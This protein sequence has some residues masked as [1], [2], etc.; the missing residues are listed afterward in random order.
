MFGS[1]RIKIEPVDKNNPKVHRVYLLELN[2]SFTCGTDE[3][4]KIIKGQFSGLRSPNGEHAGNMK[5]HWYVPGNFTKALLL[6][7]T[8]TPL[9]MQQW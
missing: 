9:P 1:Y 8:T 6:D 7:K 5:W 3:E 2:E 4:A